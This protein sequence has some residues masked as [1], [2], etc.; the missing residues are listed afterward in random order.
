MDVKLAQESFIKTKK[1]SS[2]IYESARDDLRFLSDDEFGHWDAKDVAA[3]Q[4][5]GRPV[6]QID[7]LNQYVH[8][9]TNDARMNTPSINPIPATGGDKE[10]A[11]EIKGKIRDIEYRSNAD[12]AYDAAINNSVKCSLGW[13][14]VD[15]DYD[16]D[17]TMNQ[18]LKI[19][20]VLN[21]LSCYLDADSMEIDGS[22]AM[23]GWVL[24]SLSAAEFK[25]KYKGK[26]PVSFGSEEG[27]E[28]EGEDT[29]QICEYFKIEEKTVQKVFS[30]GALVDFKDGME[31][32]TRSVKQRI[33]RRY[34]LSG[35]DILE[36][37]TFPGKYIPLIPV[38]GE[39]DFVD[40]KRRLYSLI[41][42]SK[43]AQKMFNY[44]KSLETELL[45]KQPKAKFMAAEGQVD[46]YFE[47]YANPDKA[48]VLRYRPIE[49]NGVPV[50]APIQIPPPMPPTGVIQASMMAAD[51]VRATLGIYGAGV[52][53][54]TN[55][56]SGVAIDSRK[57][58]SDTATYHFSDNLVKSITHV[59][60]V[61]V[62][63]FKEIY[64]TPRVTRIMDGEDNPKEIGINGA[65][66][67][68]QER[69]YFFNDGDY[70]VRVV[71]GAPF[72][73]RRQEAAKF[74]ENVFTRSPQLMEVMGDLMFENSDIEGADMMAERMKKV[75]DPSLF[76]EDEG[77]D[78]QTAQ[79]AQMMQQ[80]QQQM[81]QMKAELEDKSMQ[82]Q[83]DREKAQYELQK[84]QMDMQVKLE[85]L[86][87][88][89]DQ[90]QLDRARLAVETS[91]LNM[92]P[93]DIATRVTI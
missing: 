7:L 24:E 66:V 6:L 58:E 82:M 36:E 49:L 16:N 1:R 22:D 65:R 83:I 32:K 50:G 64:D 91:A 71:T 80:M 42:K 11:D 2:C 63:A 17:S 23:E 59:G 46:D 40:G 73:T 53:D 76:A 78:P 21:P 84:S 81:A 26:T 4:E 77:Q 72:T 52:G 8:Q 89:Q 55:E 20:R 18:E 48:A 61:L 93:N 43:Q 44:W 79:M 39:E 5:S 68:G 87:V 37:G 35:Q 54:R 10:T 33:V 90:Q 60:K 86:R 14:R 67:D 74:F 29:I 13:I 19:K 69:D 62:C 56:V 12:N 31:G 38:Y 30:D 3:R 85:E 47:D 25:K 34:V 45:M 75:M 9:V 57:T 27:G 41:R 88:K 70:D 15:H 51:D 28:V 92:Q